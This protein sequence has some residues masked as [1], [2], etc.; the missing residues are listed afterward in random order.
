MLDDYQHL[1]HTKHYSHHMYLCNDQCIQ[2]E[3]NQDNKLY[4]HTPPSNFTQKHK[5]YT[6]F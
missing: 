1:K 3:T 5:L 4:F 6:K 2:A